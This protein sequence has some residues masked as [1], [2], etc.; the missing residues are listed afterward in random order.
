MKNQDII[1][2]FIYFILFL[3]SISSIILLTFKITS[4]EKYEK[5]NNNNLA[6]RRTKLANQRTYLAY[7]RTGFVISGF[8][9]VFKKYWIAVFGIIM[10]IISSLQ[11]FLIN[12]QLNEK[13]YTNN[14]IFNYIPILYVL[15]SIGSLY[16]QFKKKIN[17]L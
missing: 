1:M 15:L 8:A 5:Q 4:I 2:K 16:L 13:T 17:N 9:G 10:I 11:Y 6:I 12:Q 14:K 7:M 3:G